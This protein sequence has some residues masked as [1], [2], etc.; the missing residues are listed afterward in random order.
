MKALIFFFSLFMTN[1]LASVAQC[2][3]K[4]LLTASQTIYLDSNGTIQRTVDEKSVI[5]INQSEVNIHVNDEQK[6]MFSIK[7]NTCKWNVPFR[8]GKT[9]IKGSFNKSPEETITVTIDIEGKDGKITLIFKMENR[10]EIIK[11]IIE[12]FEE[13][14]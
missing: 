12:K 3:K 4:L 14:S 10:P 11:V 5:Q 6:M 13:V 8:E 2:G 1:T 7:T 9:F